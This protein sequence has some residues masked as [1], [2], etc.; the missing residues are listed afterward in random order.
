V[1]S[2]SGLG[3]GPGFSRSTLL[4]LLCIGLS[5]VAVLAASPALAAETHPYTGISFGPAGTSKGSAFNK[6]I[7]GIAVDP[8]NGNVYVYDWGA[9]EIYKFDS[10][11]NPLDFSGLANGKPI[12]GVPAAPFN[13]SENQIA[14]APPGSPGGTAGDIYVANASALL[15]YGPDGLKLGEITELGEPCG[16]AT[17]PSGHV[18]V[19]SY[20]TTVREFIP[21]ANPFTS[22]DESEEGPSVAELPEICN[23]AADELGNVYAASYGGGTGVYKL[24]GLKAASPTQLDPIGASI[25]VDPA[26]N[27]V[28]VIHSFQAGVSQYDPSGTLVNEFGSDQL[29]E[30]AGIAIN[31]SSGNIYVGNAASDRVEV[32]GPLV[33]LPTVK[34]EAASAITPAKATLNA[35]V[36][37]E[38][39]AVTSCKFEY[40][41][42]TAY[43]KE[44][45]C[46]GAL[47]TDSSD[48]SVT[49]AL[50]G[51]ERQAE[52]HFRVVATNANG[53]SASKDLTFTTAGA[54]FTGEAT[55][56]TG[57][58]AILNGVVSPEGEVVSECK[59]EYGTTTAYGKEVP[60]EGA[61]PVDEGEHSVTAA[62]VH[63]VPNGTTYHFRLVVERPS[64]TSQGPDRS[65]VT[66]ETVITLAASAA[67]PS[68]ATI[69]GTVNPEGTPL[70]ECKFEYGPTNA[71]GSSE[72]CAE[73]PATIGE[74][75]SPVS[76][77]ADL[78]GLAVGATYHYRLV[79][80]N[81]DGTAQ[82][83]DRRLGLPLIEDQQVQGVTETE[84]ELV[85]T[86]N[87][88][89]LPA[90][91]HLEYGTTASYGQ[92]TAE[93]GVGSD[94]EGHALASPL[95]GLAPDT[96]YHWRTV[97]DGADGVSKGADR[98]FTTFATFSPETNCPNQAFR[99]GASAALPD[100]RA[101][102]MVSPSQKAGEVFPPDPSGGLS[103]TCRECLPGEINETMPMQIAPGG[104]SVVYEGLPFSAGLSASANEYLAKRGSDG[105][106][107]QG[108]SLPQF[109]NGGQGQGYKA[110]S[111]DLSRGALFQVLPALS[112]EAPTSDGEGFA[113]IYLR[114][115]DGFLRPLLTQAPPNRG[116]G[117]SCSSSGTSS[118]KEFNALFGGGN[119]G[120]ASAPPFDHLV[121][122]ANDALTGA[123]ATAPA[124]V[125]GG[126]H[127]EIEARRVLPTNLDLYEWY[128]GQLRL[129]N[130]QPGNTATSPGAV[131]GSGRLLLSD[132]R[133]TNAVDHA[134]S[135]DGSRIF[136]SQEGSGQVYVR[137]D[138]KETVELTDH[139]GKFL[140][141]TPDG[142]EV[143][144]NDGCVYDLAEEECKAELSA[145]QGGFQ[146][147]LGASEDL[148]RIYF[149]DT[150]ALTSSDEENDNGEHAAEGE[151][152][153]YAW[154]EGTPAFI[155][156]LRKADN[157]LTLGNKYGDWKPSST[158]RVAQVSSDGRYL[159]FMSKA[160]LTGYD[161]ALSDP[162][163]NSLGCGAGRCF[164][165]FEYEA[166]SGALSCASCNP[167]GE[168]PLG[169]SNLSLISAQQG[170]NDSPP[171]FPQPGN[172][173]ENGRGR[174]F[175]ES[176]DTLTPRD[177]N[178]HITDV[179]EWEPDGV[180][181]CKRAAGCVSL[182]SSGQSPNDS[183]FVD[184][185][186]SG[187]DALIITR[188][189]LLLKDKD[190]QLDLYD[191]RA[192]GG[193]SEAKAPP[194]QGEACKGPGTSAGE[195][196]S[197]GSASFVGPGNEK[198][199]KHKHK[200]KRHKHKS[201]AHK[202]AAKHNSGGTK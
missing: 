60:C 129:V 16:V 44:A 50:N 201:K 109:S 162:H 79:A 126:V 30:S 130:V 32:F 81:A 95:A 37:P 184:S 114:S 200:K 189:Q 35:R 179:Y 5:L 40:G 26:N 67:G 57:A 53:P 64:G 15:I 25:A 159:A 1:E 190:D 82:G 151:N 17:T 61:I 117:L 39:L 98:T 195:Q 62:L 101:Y 102:E 52:Y 20:P 146:G 104:E 75:N 34:A 123:T 152:N 147:I 2:N 191:A 100:C 181:G 156:V 125:D 145:G 86:I 131:L 74:G 170:R 33:L 58:K 138:G 94:E 51:L 21:S 78:S 87:P 23:V 93:T 63:L 202:R 13:A 163:T 45:P 134:I 177:T 175:F 89:G 136:W 171:L 199:K 168:R 197:S 176:Q 139:T 80:T 99:T 150:K 112:P 6:G 29:A 164:E 48:H 194:C 140:T 143:L 128:D 183:M 198:A 68:T 36:N 71:Y 105:W 141:A 155:G 157:E 106:V 103:S 135:N 182:I 91:Y 49:A 193:I 72:S 180:G 46:E 153:L 54:A 73:S 66:T 11:G 59:F 161:N 43:G 148:T 137:I 4:G 18:F 38:G 19:G 22:G 115:P 31:G 173:S 158:D 10:S 88:N 196:L 107:T 76:V 144:L 69:K 108:L 92:S 56:I 142:S 97:A 77:H 124:A 47:P 9:G 169:G 186:P 84:A 3:S 166:D 90:T 85:A 96:T 65:F 41:T 120:T 160:P 14:V 178:G 7:A 119:P 172:L 42:T 185:T 187:S 165:V 12:E 55:A 8:S 122:A 111:S 174:L 192:D 24:E 28:Y 127:F 188:E 110:F 149:I 116:P 133:E 83:K 27:N 154:H 121:F 70:T 132:E 167:S 118:C 113:N